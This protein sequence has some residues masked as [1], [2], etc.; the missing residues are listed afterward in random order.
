MK[1]EWSD[2]VDDLREL[3][4]QA[5]GKNY[6]TELSGILSSF[7]NILDVGCGAGILYED[8]K[9]LSYVGLDF[10]PEFIECCHTLYPEGVWILADGHSLPFADNSFAVVNSTTVLQHILSWERVAEEMIRVARDYV[11]V[12]ARTWEQETIV[13]ALEPCVRIRFN[14]KTLVDFFTQ[15]GQVD[16]HWTRNTNGEERLLAIY[17]VKLR[18]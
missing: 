16:W 7:D 15:F 6:R 3:W 4:S 8:M 14:S 11:I 17:I 12:T 1:T 9:K 10:T 18:E 2:R 5:K 13:V